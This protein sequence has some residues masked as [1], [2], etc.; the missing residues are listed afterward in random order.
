MGPWCE[1][2]GPWDHRLW[3]LGSDMFG[4][5]GPMCTKPMWVFIVGSIPAV[6]CLWT[7]ALCGQSSSHGS[8]R[9]PP[10]RRLQ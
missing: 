9:Y 1:D 3:A 4:H 5:E 7:Q 8:V 6:Q 2:Q 10:R